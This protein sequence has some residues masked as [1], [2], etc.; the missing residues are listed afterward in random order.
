[1]RRRRS[2]TLR[3]P[4][5]EVLIAPQAVAAAL[6][7]STGCGEGQTKFI[8]SHREV[9]TLDAGSNTGTTTGSGIGGDSGG[10]SEVT[11]EVASI[12]SEI[13]ADPF[14]SKYADAQGIPVLSSPEAS[15]I[16]LEHAC[17]IVQRMLALRDDVR[18][19][20]IARGAR[21][22]VIAPHERLSDLPELMGVSNSLANTRGIGAW[23]GQPLTI[24]AEENLLCLEN[25][26]Y[27]GEIILVHSMAHAMR[28]LGIGSLEPDFDRRLE[29]AYQSSVY[30]EG[31][32]R[33][34]FASESF[35]QYWAEGVQ[36]WFD[37]NLAPPNPYH[38]EINTRSELAE[39]DPSLYA[40]I[41]DYFEP[42]ADILDCF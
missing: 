4:G 30:F 2:R 20:M 34:A 1:M 26:V 23:V 29:A 25:D 32:W 27:R 3:Q 42:T 18:S 36:C 13:E 10:P 33:D 19:E 40:I 28:A 15:D 16:A 37:A 11:C 35:P 24:A 22:A 8:G 14:Y 38:N 6:A 9:T 21:I 17:W 39:Y 31:K 7:L 12:P 5:C 41:E